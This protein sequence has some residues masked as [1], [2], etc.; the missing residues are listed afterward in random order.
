[1]RWAPEIPRVVSD[2]R[3][4]LLNV[5][6]KLAPGRFRNSVGPMA[7]MD[8]RDASIQVLPI[9]TTLLANQLDNA[10]IPRRARTQEMWPSNSSKSDGTCET[11]L[12]T[13]MRC[14]AVSIHEK[15][16]F[17]GTLD[18]CLAGGREIELMLCTAGQV[19]GRTTCSLSIFSLPSRW[20]G[21]A[22]ADNTRNAGFFCLTKVQS[23][24]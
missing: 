23:G 5:F 1:M 4:L 8:P 19:E 15:R 11:R 22:S 16:F 6:Q 9:W 10:L 24:T 18:S 2:H 7:T 21:G 14:R 12:S 13:P 20:E 17:L 3:H